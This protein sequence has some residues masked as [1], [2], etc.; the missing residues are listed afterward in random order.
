MKPDIDS[1]LVRLRDSNTDHPQLPQLENL[2]WQRLE[3]REL[4]SFW[5]RM[6]IPLRVTAIVGAFVWGILIGLNVGPFSKSMSSGQL[7]VEQA[8]FLAPLSDDSS[9]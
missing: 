5:R 8:E 4:P 3:A 7:L 1:L 6:A 2:L 9:P